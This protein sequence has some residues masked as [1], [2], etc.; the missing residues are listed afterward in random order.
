MR[1]MALFQSKVTVGKW[2]KELIHK[3]LLKLILSVATVIRE[4]KFQL[5]H[6]LVSPEQNPI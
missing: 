5:D 3:T 2:P 6:L 1:K 4:S